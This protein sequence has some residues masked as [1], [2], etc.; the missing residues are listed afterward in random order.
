MKKNI[1]TVA[2]ISFMVGFSQNCFAEIVSQKNSIS[3]RSGVKVFF[4]GVSKHINAKGNPNESHEMVGVSYSRFE[5]MRM[6]NSYRKTS[7]ILSR[8][9]NVDL[10]EFDNGIV[11]F[12]IRTGFA[13]GY[14]KAK[15]DF[16]GFIPVVQPNIY[17]E[18]NCGIGF[19][20]GAV[21]YSGE[22][23]DGVITLSVSYKF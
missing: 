17:F 13:S 11:E 4:A 20:L 18:H 19:E 9:N 6:K 16:G 14:E 7:V 15:H 10:L 23:S 2:I 12:N 1:Y 8:N 5:L 21:P 22:Q 3:E